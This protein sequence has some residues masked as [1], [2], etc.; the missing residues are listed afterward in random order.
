MLRRLF[1]AAVIVGWTVWGYAAEEAAPPKETP[2]AAEPK[3]D[4]AKKPDAKPDEKKDAKKD[5]AKK[6]EAKKDQEIVVS[7]EKIPVG[8]E[9][10][11]ASVTRVTDRDIQI[12][13]DNHAAEILRMV[14]GVAINQSGRR[15]DFAQV[16][17]RGGETDHALVMF[18][19][20][21]VNT[22]GR[23][24]QYNFD[25]LDP[26]GVQ[27]MEVVRG[28]GSAL[29]G[30]DAVTGS[31]NLITKKG[32]GRP[33]LTAS[34]AGG[35][36][37][38]DREAVQIEGSVDFFSYNV[39]ASRQHRAGS[40]VVNSA[41]TMLNHAAR[42]DF[43]IDP[44]HAVK[45]LVRNT[46]IDKGF[47]E[48][49]P[50]GYGTGI[51]AADPNDDIRDA[52]NFAGIEYTGQPFEI[53]ETILRAGYFDA[54]N[55]SITKAPNLDSF[56]SFQLDPFGF[57]GPYQRLPS[58]SFTHDQRTSFEWTNNVTVYKD[59]HIRDVFTAGYY[60]EK[61]SFTDRFQGLEVDFAPF[62][63]GTMFSRLTDHFDSTNHSFYAQNRLELYDRAFLTAGW[64]REDHGIFGNHDTFRGDASILIPESDTRIFGSAGTSFR[65]PAF[66]E[67]YGRF[68][69]NPALKPE[70]NMS[71]DI[72]F[73]QHFLKRK[74]SF[75]ATYFTNN[76]S[77]L[78]VNTFNPLTFEFSFDNLGKAV[79]H[80]WEFFA[81][82]RPVKQLTIEGTATTMKSRDGIIFR[83]LGRRPEQTYTA[84]LTAQPLADL[85]PDAWDGLDFSLEFFSVSNQRDVGPLVPV[86]QL[87]PFDYTNAFGGPSAQVGLQSIG[88]LKYKRDG[89]HRFDLAVS[90][91]FW[92]DRLRAFARVENLTNE[93]YEDIATF[94]GDGANILGG[95][96]FSWRF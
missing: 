7:A 63:P 94:P 18:D 82:F 15:G 30:S 44:R 6:E 89:Y 12:N 56:L 67:L 58:R 25:A 80:G 31:I 36:F 19:G 40:E 71:W 78:I 3:A 95:L 21:K 34:A 59:E 43:Q 8:R 79:T 76:F 69:G 33:K 26:V 53:W 16:R 46:D 20:F 92:K 28:A 37:G 68:G 50:S 32:E 47:Y 29:H 54:E 85:V 61:E 57:S 42:F 77:N 9:R 2:K 22:S 10:T 73:E 83:R 49:N 86:V 90:Y 39:A 14:P 88:V 62:P 23:I 45:L 5:E 51:E 27:Q 13:Q 87:Q 55:T 72:G 70:T 91:R 17:I 4:E 96:E 84:R 93:Q 66:G 48:S 65:A 52:S 11:G 41:F 74:I 38:T 35:T 1:I 75:G 60:V 64:R 81:R 24:R